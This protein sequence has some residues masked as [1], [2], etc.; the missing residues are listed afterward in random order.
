MKKEN[1]K[2]N[3]FLEKCNITILSVFPESF[4]SND[5][6]RAEANMKKDFNCTWN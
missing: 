2:N 5:I 3:G 1:E 6:Q 4:T